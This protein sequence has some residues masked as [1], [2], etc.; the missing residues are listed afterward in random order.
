[1]GSGTA[2]LALYDYVSDDC[3]F[4]KV[5]RLAVKRTFEKRKKVEMQFRDSFS[6]P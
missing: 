4:E 1:V 6:F 5:E 2:Q 3:C